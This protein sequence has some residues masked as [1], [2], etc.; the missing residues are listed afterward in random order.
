MGHTSIFI[1]IIPYIIL[2][3]YLFLFL[4][5]YF[6]LAFGPLTIFPEDVAHSVNYHNNILLLTDTIILFEIAL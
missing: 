5:E 6:L 1:I 4:I 3:H 2:C